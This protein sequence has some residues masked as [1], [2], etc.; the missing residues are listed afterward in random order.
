M[1]DDRWEWEE[2]PPQLFG[3]SLHF[4]ERVYVPGD[5]HTRIQAAKEAGRTTI[6]ARI[7]P[8]GLKEAIRYSIGPANRHYR[9]HLLTKE[10]LLK[11]V[12]TALKD[13]EM[14]GWTDRR[15]TDYCSDGREGLKQKVVSDQ[16]KKLLAQWELNDPEEFHWRA[17]ELS[18]LRDVRI[19]GGEYIRSNHRNQ[20]REKAREP[21]IQQLSEPIKSMVRRRSAESSMTELQWVEAVILSVDGMIAERSVLLDR[22]EL[23]ESKVVAPDRSEEETRYRYIGSPFWAETEGEKAHYIQTGDILLLVDEDEEFADDELIV[24]PEKS[25]WSSNARLSVHIDKLEWIYR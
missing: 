16:R 9:S 15:I 22:L 19:D 12:Q 13:R 11:R 25:S 10:D 17:N 2:S 7:H 4:G 23:L 3:P 1:I 8:G 20:V 21:L 6:L 5:G 18:R 14:W 24:R